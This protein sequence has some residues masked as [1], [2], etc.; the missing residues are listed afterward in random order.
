M[1]ARWCAVIIVIPAFFPWNSHFHDSR[2]VF[3]AEALA[4]LYHSRGPEWAAILGHNVPNAPGARYSRSV[5]RT[6]LRPCPTVPDAQVF[7]SHSPDPVCHMGKRSLNL[8]RQ[9]LSIHVSAPIDAP[10]VAK[11][12][13]FI[14]FMQNME[15]FPEYDISR[16]QFYE[17]PCD[18]RVLLC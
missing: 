14:A 5:L 13:L 15:C 6:F 12:S 11:Q 2:Y 17:D 16:Q 4:E 18:L 8:K 3:L 7:P 9:M 1:I 10:R